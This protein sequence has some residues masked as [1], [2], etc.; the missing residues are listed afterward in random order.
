MLPAL[1]EKAQP[2]CSGGFPLDTHF[3]ADR[4]APRGEHGVPSSRVP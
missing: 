4:V 2:I 3:A 1:V